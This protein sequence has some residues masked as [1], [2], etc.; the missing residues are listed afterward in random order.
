MNPRA[1]TIDA[2]ETGRDLDDAV[3]GQARVA[4]DE[5]LA[6]AGVAT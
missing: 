1:F 3:A 2:V 4:V 6:R 5:A